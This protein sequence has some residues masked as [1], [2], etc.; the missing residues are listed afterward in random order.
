MYVRL[1]RRVA[2]SHRSNCPPVYFE[3][4]EVIPDGIALHPSMA[5]SR[6]DPP[7]DITVGQVALDLS[8]P[9]PTARNPQV[10]IYV[11]TG[12]TLSEEEY[13][14]ELKHR[15]EEGWTRR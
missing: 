14:W 7:L 4:F 6:D 2:G 8:D 3:R 15:P 10:T 11:E 5:I 12:D 13:A 1:M 9:R